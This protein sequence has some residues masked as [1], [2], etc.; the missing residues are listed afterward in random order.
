ML[1]LVNIP[2]LICF[3]KSDEIKEILVAL[4]IYI[5][6]YNYFT[7]TTTSGMDFLRTL[8]ENK[9][10]GNSLISYH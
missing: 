7:F 10:I 1:Y 2:L 5:Y 3:M 4:K 9:H 6:N 8:V